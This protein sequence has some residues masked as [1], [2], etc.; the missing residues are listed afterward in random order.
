MWIV[1]VCSLEFWIICW[2]ILLNIVPSSNKIENWLKVI[3]RCTKFT[4]LCLIIILWVTCYKIY[5]SSRDVICLFWLWQGA[6][7]KERRNKIHHQW[8]LLLQP[9]FDHQRRRCRGHPCS[10]DQGLQNRVASHVEKLGAKLAKQLIPQWTKPLLPSHRQWRKNCHKL[11][12]GA[13]WLAVRSDI[14]RV[15]ILNFL[16]GLKKKKS[17]CIYNM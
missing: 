9:G 12:R 10:L 16:I 14:P 15:S 6:L 1:A 17:W 7:C 11:Q 2:S 3:N 4:Y 5:L 8:S 13:H